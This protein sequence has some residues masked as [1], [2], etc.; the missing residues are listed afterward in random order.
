[1]SDITVADLAALGDTALILDIR[2]DDEFAVV[3]VPGVLHIPMSELLRRLPEVPTQVPVHVICAVGGRSA[4][5]AEYLHGTGMN[6]VNV[7][8]GTVAWERAGFA[9][10]SGAV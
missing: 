5:V 4:Q 6:A 3:R 10:E 9:V 1:M 8:G 2:E 7:L